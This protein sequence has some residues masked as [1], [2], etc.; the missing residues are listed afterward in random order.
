MASGMGSQ[1]GYPGQGLPGQPGMPVNSQMGGVSPYPMQPGA[2]GVPPGFPQPGT[3]T[4]QG[5]AAADMIRNILTTP[6]PGGM[7][8]GNPGAQMFGGG[9]AGVAS[10]AEGEGVKVYN[11]R[12]LY[13]EW[14]FIFDPAKQKRIPNPNGG[15]MGG[16]PMGNEGGITNTGQPGAPGF[17]QQTAKPPGQ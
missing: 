13:Q 2:N 4:A 7:P 17:G 12:S 1:A 5:N 8:Q 15:G 16:T 6:R 10:T 14:E 11:E 9:I 3:T